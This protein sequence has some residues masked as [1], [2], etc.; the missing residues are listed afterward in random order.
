MS[1]EQKCSCTSDCIACRTAL[2]Q[3]SVIVHQL[4]E[5]VADLH[6]E[7]IEHRACIDAQGLLLDFLERCTP[8]REAA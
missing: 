1:H 4:V 6:V 3:L 2:G 8:I 7:I 5:Q